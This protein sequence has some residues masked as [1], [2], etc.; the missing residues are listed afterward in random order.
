MEGNRRGIERVDTGID[1]FF[2]LQFPRMRP[3]ANGLRNPQLGQREFLKHQ[4]RLTSFV[5]DAHMAVIN[6][7]QT[8]I[9]RARQF[10]EQQMMASRP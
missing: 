5:N 10:I 3:T 2:R 7:G 1:Q 4:L 9:A 8:G 6:A